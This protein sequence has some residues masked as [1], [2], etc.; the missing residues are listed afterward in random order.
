M[1]WRIPFAILLVGC[2][3]F[4]LW[5]FRLLSTIVPGRHFFCSFCAV[6]THRRDSGECVRLWWRNECRAKCVLHSHTTYVQLDLKR[7]S[8]T[9]EWMA[10][11]RQMTNTLTYRLVHVQVHCPSNP[12]PNTRI[13]ATHHFTWFNFHMQSAVLHASL[14]LQPSLVMIHFAL[15]VV[16]IR[17]CAVSSNE[18]NYYAK[19]SEE[20]KKKKKTENWTQSTEKEW[21]VWRS[22]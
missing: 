2:V 13:T 21:I 22:E 16:R 6:F 12:P 8:N 18:W 10:C 9:N 14:S 7:L 3:A 5:G 1:L 19:R 15:F 11:T 4:L 20:N 17:P